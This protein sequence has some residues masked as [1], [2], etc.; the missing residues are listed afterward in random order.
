MA[1]KKRGF[2][3]SSETDDEKKVRWGKQ[4]KQARS[5]ARQAGI[6]N[7]AIKEREELEKFKKATGSKNK[8]F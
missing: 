8:N 2:G 1:K 4:L 3:I 5:F 7:T 6:L